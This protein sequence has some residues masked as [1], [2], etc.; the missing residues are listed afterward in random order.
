MILS[1]Q[2]FLSLLTKSLKSEKIFRIFLKH[3]SYES[4][5]FC[6]VSS[7][8]EMFKVSFKNDKFPGS[9]PVLKNFHSSSKFLKYKI[10]RNL[11]FKYNSY[12][13]PRKQIFHSIQ[14]ST[15]FLLK[16]YRLINL[17]SDNSSKPI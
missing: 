12:H 3:F 15:F 5:I 6:K 11:F 17:S 8:S 9:F 4:K 1:K 7:L 13:N 2:L 16:I 10:F 14:I